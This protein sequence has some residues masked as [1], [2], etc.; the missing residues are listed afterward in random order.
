LVEGARK[1]KRGKVHAWP[2]TRKKEGASPSPTKEAQTTPH[3][4]RKRG[5]KR[6]PE[7]E[8]VS[9][10]ATWAG[11]EKEGHAIASH[12]PEKSGDTFLNA[13]RGEG[14]KRNRIVT[15]NIVLGYKGRSLITSRNVSSATKRA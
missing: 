5:K 8:T 4:R 9:F 3:G 10:Q 11:K 15:S 7:E 14:K 2:P 12:V 13:V 6:T 1:G